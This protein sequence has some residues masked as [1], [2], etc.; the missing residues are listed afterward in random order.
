MTTPQTPIRTDRIARL[1][2]QCRKENRA[3]L[4]LYITAGYPDAA[5]TRSLLPVLADAGCD[6]IELGIPF[7]DP[8]ADGPTIQRASTEA[9]QNGMTLRGALDL[10]REFRVRH[11]IPVIPFG[12]MNP[13]LAMGVEQ[14]VREFREAGA[15]GFLVADLPME[16]ADEFRRSLREAGM[17]LIALVAPTTP[18]ARIRS[19]AEKSS[20]FLYCISMKGTTGSLGGLSAEASEY[21]ARVRAATNL[22]LALGFGIS[23]PEHARAAVEAGA[24]GVVVGS[25]LIKCIDEARQAG[26]PVEQAVRDYVVSL[27]C[28]VQE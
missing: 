14:C 15:D 22:P 5:T 13:F 3:A 18:S 23:S 25:A 2:A 16:E 11:E 6:L 28:A 24:D 21:L 17:H 8:I 27:R 4:I 26:Q 9:L 20:G 10:L 19:I 12:A 1:F 7:S